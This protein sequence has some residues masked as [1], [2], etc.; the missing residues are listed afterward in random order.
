MALGNFS[1]LMLTRPQSSLEKRGW[2]ARGVMGRKKEGSRLADPD[3]NMADSL[4][5]GFI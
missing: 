1:A 5:A 2:G 3:F 4:M